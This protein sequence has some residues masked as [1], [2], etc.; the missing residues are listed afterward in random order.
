[1]HPFKSLSSGL[2]SLLAATSSV[3]LPLTES[4]VI[5]MGSLPSMTVAFIGPTAL[6]D[7]P[8]DIISLG[9]AGGPIPMGSGMGSGMA[10][11]TFNGFSAPRVPGAGGVPIKR[12]WFR[13]ADYIVSPED[14][15]FAEPTTLPDK[16]INKRSS[17]KK[18]SSGKASH[19]DSNSNNINGGSTVSP[20]NIA[21]NNA[22]GSLPVPNLALPGGMDFSSPVKMT[23]GSLR[24]ASMSRNMVSEKFN[25]IASGVFPKP[26]GDADAGPAANLP[27]TRREL[28]PD[29]V[30]VE[31]LHGKRHSLQLSTEPLLPNQDDVPG[32]Q[33]TQ[34][35]FDENREMGIINWDSNAKPT[36]PKLSDVGADQIDSDDTLEDLEDDTTDKTAAARKLKPAT[37]GVPTTFTSEKLDAAD[38]GVPTVSG[39]LKP[40]TGG[41]PTTLHS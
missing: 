22:A 2:F 35:E 33:M 40:A 7:V 17:R 16:S 9:K 28:S 18:H 6:P 41:V 1:M 12:S 38:E 19:K 15:L 24:S 5:P 39:D 37:G 27:S 31:S 14:H 10:P 32:H 21:Q 3:A 36:A 13:E 4:T 11:P 20:V 29:A 26:P 23:A 8:L 25:G 30:H 34:E